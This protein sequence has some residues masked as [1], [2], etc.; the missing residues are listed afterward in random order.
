MM[1][2][3]Q[4]VAPANEQNCKFSETSTLRQ[5]VDDHARRFSGRKNDVD[6]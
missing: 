4:I 2:D 5:K 6:F 3:N 1:A